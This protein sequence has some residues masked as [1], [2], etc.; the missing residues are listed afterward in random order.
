M[1]Y[2]TSNTEQSIALIP[3]YSLRINVAS[4][5]ILQEDV[6]A[7]FIWVSAY[8]NWGSFYIDNKVVSVGDSSSNI[9]ISTFSGFIPKGSK[10]SWDGGSI[11]F[12]EVD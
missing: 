1:K 9:V 5:D 11:K 4:G 10:V 3:N 2:V 8:G 6:Y 12:F 7:E